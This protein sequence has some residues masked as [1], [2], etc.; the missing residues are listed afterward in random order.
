MGTSK[1]TSVSAA[2]AHPHVPR[3][4]SPS[5]QPQ[6]LA[7]TIS[8]LREAGKMPD[9]NCELLP[10]AIQEEMMRHLVDLLHLQAQ[11]EQTTTR[12]QTATPFSK[13]E[14]QKRL[15]PKKKALE[16]LRSW[17]EALQ[18]R[19][20]RLEAIINNQ[21]PEPSE[22]P[23]A[24]VAKAVKHVSKLKKVLQYLGQVFRI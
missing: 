23:A 14:I 13:E 7:D 3:P 1:V 15:E 21:Q 4:T 20:E 11:L 8:T 24:A 2:S 17:T 9:P 16:R 19:I 5:Q 6:S 18:K 12:L 10:L 22:V